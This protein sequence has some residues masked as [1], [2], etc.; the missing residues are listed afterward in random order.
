MGELYQI[1][2]KI[3]ALGISLGQSIIQFYNLSA[4]VL[5][6]CVATSFHSHTDLT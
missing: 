5:P 4:L 3:Q 1:F 2:E 6:I